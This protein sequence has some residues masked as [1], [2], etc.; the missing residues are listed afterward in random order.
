MAEGTTN[1]QLCIEYQA[2]SFLIFSFNLV[3]ISNKDSP[4]SPMSCNLPPV[5]A[6]QTANSVQLTWTNTMGSCWVNAW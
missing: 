4:N 5:C 1:I 3:N 6:E 2:F